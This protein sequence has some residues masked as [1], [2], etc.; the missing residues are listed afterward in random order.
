[1]IRLSTTRM[2]SLLLVL[3]ASVTVA[4]EAAA[5]EYPSR[6]VEFIVSFPAG[7]PAD[8]GARVLAPLMSSLLKQNVVVVNKPGGGGA[9]GADFAAKAKP[10]GHTLYVSTNS[11]LTISP[12]LK[13]LP[14]KRSD[15]TPIG[16]FAVDL[17]VITVRGT[18]PAKTLEEF[19]GYAKK[20]P[21]KLNYG[22]AGYGTVSFFTMELF[23]LA[24][25]L[26]LVHVP[27]QGTG[28]VK[29]AIMGGHVTVATSGFGSLS[30]LIRSGDLVALVTT[31]P[32]RV[33]A[34][35]NVPTM[36]EKGFP[37]ASLNIW[38]GLYAPAA[39]PKP[40][41]EQLVK[42]MAQVAKDPALAAGLEKAG[43]HLDYRDPAGTAKL[44][45]TE[46]TAVGKVV[47][48]LKLPKE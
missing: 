11:V 5:A 43:M 10:D 44:L 48:K 16:A 1:M 14:Y 32:K 15:F 40:I 28:P 20:N 21:G 24:Y 3:L 45:E 41:V 6:E 26:D 30:P 31:A 7:G 47:E 19:V 38:M 35:P 22:S 34:F 17:G 36:T 27:F 42:A 9:V 13:K 33:A 23:K 46:T 39:T 2:V 37:D 12:H 18:S 25:G 29:N 8:S 4:G